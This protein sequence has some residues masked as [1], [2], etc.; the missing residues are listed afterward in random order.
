MELYSD[1]TIVCNQGLGEVYLLTSDGTVHTASSLYDKEELLRRYH[2]QCIETDRFCYPEIIWDSP[3]IKCQTLD[4][5]C[6][7][8]HVT[9]R[10]GKYREGDPEDE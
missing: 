5:S 3:F 7:E 4:W 1:D 10:C 8:V 6:G 9:L 2:M